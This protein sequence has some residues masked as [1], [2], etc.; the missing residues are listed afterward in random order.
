MGSEMETVIGNVD[1]EL[2]GRFN[3]IRTQETNLGKITN[4]SLKP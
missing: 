1:V 4:L 3:K 2:D